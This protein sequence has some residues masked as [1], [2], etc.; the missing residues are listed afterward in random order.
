[1]CCRTTIG[2][3]SPNKQGTAGVHGAALGDEEI[4]ATR[5]A[6]GWMHPAWEI[7]QEYYEAWGQT[8]RGGD[9]QRAWQEEYDRFA[10]AEP[11]KAAEFERRMAGE[12]PENWSAAVDALASQEQQALSVVETRKASQRCIGAIAAGIPELFGGSAD[13][14]GSNNTRWEGAT[15]DQHMSYGVREFAMTAI[16]NGL[17]LHGGYRP[18]SYTHLRAH[19]T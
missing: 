16:S 2:F 4:A 15:D 10:A 1:M 18:V 9:R 17:Q 12:L 13:L 3:G 14:T 19:E 5:E 11:A 8:Q 7:P 6:L